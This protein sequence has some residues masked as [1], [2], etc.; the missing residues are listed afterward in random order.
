MG[1]E[2]CI[3]DRDSMD[4][5]NDVVEYIATNK[6]SKVDLFVAYTHL[7]QN[8]SKMIYQGDSYIQTYADLTTWALDQGFIL[9]EKVLDPIRFYNVVCVFNAASRWEISRDLIDDKNPDIEKTRRIDIKNL[10]LAHLFS[11]KLE[12]HTALEL[13]LIHI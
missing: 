9:N 13:S 3:R 10:A 1:S 5:Y 6:F 8:L 12:P 11:Y 7:K 2:M 4:I